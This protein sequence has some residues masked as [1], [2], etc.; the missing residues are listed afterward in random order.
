MGSPR[1]ASNVEAGTKRVR[2]A[3]AV[4]VLGA[5]GFIGREVAR[6]LLLR[7]RRVVAL[8]RGQ[9]DEAARDRVGRAVGAAAG[10]RLEVVR[11]DLTL[12]G[13]GLGDSAVRRLRE[14][15]ETVL[16]CAGD[17][18]FQPETMGSFR[19]GHI[20][21]P[22][23]LALRLH[24]SRL[25]RWGHLS[26]AYVCGR[27]SGTVGESEADVGQS[28]HNPYERIK[29]ESEMSIRVTGRR[30]GLGVTVFRPSIVVG[31]G[32]DTVGAGPSLLFFGLIR[33]VAALAQQSGGGDVSLRLPLAP[34]ARLNIV[35][36]EYV[37]DAVVT[38]VA[39]PEA[40]DQTFH[41]VAEGG[42][43]QEMVDTISERCGISGVVLVDP[44]RGALDAP[45]PIE[46]R[47]DRMLAGYRDYLAQEL[48][49]DDRNARRLLDRL[50]V[51]RPQL[52]AEALRR[53]TDRALGT[54]GEH[55]LS[56]HR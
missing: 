39:H 3:G 20:D 46:A 36:V 28:F 43:N 8:A 19:A 21:G 38:L 48:R 53:L 22:R 13:C 5:T 1:V 55:L 24:G 32:S 52:S 29:L 17:T 42:L 15:V 33:I 9:D 23:E 16:H 40:A 50:G 31:E 56:T 11:G 47:I 41:L 51:A 44:R 49:F 18:S 45:S 14:Q 2:A 34:R 37:A 7:G 35:P 54:P 27:R 12:P 26:T 6:R 25:A 30:L 4:L 10:G